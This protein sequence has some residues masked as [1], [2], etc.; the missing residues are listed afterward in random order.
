MERLA[1]RVSEDGGVLG[2]DVRGWVRGE[3][4]CGLGTFE[5]HGQGEADVRGRG[6]ARRGLVY[7]DRAE[8]VAF[9]VADASDLVY[10]RYSRGAREEEVA[11]HVL[12]GSYTL[13][14]A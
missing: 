14:D 4:G 11:C 13:V 9:A 5:R 3:E 12:E 7:V 10:E 8:D 6:G 1:V 2:W